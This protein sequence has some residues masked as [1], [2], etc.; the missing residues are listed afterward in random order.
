MTEPFAGRLVVVG[1]GIAGVSAAGA[2]RAAGVEG[3]IVVLDAEGELPYRRPPVSKEVL[4]GDKDADGIRIKPASWYEAQRIDL[5]SGVA[6]TGLDREARELTLSDGSTLGYD[7]LIL[8]TGGQARQPW[9]ASGV[10]TIRSLADLPALQSALAPGEPLVV[11]GA[12]L[13]GSEIAASARA[14]GAEVVLLETA[15]RPLPRLLPPLLAD[16]YADLHAEAGTELLLGVSV[17]DVS[18]GDDGRTTV[19]LDDGRSF[20]SAVVVAAVGMAPD[21]AL[22]EAAGLELA[23]GVGGIVVDAA[24]RTADPAVWAAGDVAAF[25]HPRTGGLTRVEH[26]QHAQRH[27]T[28]VGQVAA[29]LDV[30]YDDVPWAWSDQY[31]HTLQTTG[32]PSADPAAAQTTVVRGSLADRD[33]TVFFLDDGEVVGAVALGRPAE[34]RL[35]RTWIADHARPDPVALA[36]DTAALAAA[37]S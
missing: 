11:I 28:A 4:R 6:A 13:I 17:A 18:T 30:T 20:T 21:V 16:V 29:G 12:G 31:G 8:A 7:R 26:W 2:A 37:V 5:R 3:E 14:A 22:A 25:P 23:A 27:G 24:G 33:A 36:D 10:V 32:W 9:D 15:P 1:A 35:A 34:I 19:T